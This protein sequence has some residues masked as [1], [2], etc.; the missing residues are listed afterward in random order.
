MTFH[1]RT[2]GR[3]GVDR[4]LGHY[5]ELYWFGAGSRTSVATDPDT[6]QPP[7]QPGR[8]RGALPRRRSLSTR[9]GA[10]VSDGGEGPYGI[11]GVPYLTPDLC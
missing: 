6:C 5:S 7:A 1:G 4:G 3:A 10:G 11:R 2:R 9:T 8:A